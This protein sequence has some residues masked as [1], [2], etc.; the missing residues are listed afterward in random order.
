MPEMDGYEVIA[1]LKKSEKTTHIPVMF[2]SGLLDQKAMD[3]GFTLGAAD[4]ILKPFDPDAV[5]GKIRKL[6][7][8]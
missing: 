6:L 3:K 7:D 2:I 5:K 8:R 1:A 4:Y